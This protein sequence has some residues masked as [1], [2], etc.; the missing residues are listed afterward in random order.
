MKLVEIYPLTVVALR[1]FRNKGGKTHSGQE[2]VTIKNATDKVKL[3]TGDKK[4]NLFKEEKILEFVFTK[5]KEWKEG[6]LA[7]ESNKK[8]SSPYQNFSKQQKEWSK[9]YA[10]GLSKTIKSSFDLQK[11]KDKLTRDTNVSSKDI[12]KYLKN[13]NAIK[14]SLISEGWH[15]GIENYSFVADMSELEGHLKTSRGP[16]KCPKCSN[17]L[18]FK[19]FSKEEDKEENE[20][21]SWKCVCPSCKSKLTVF[22]T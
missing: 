12:A 6:K 22:N 1:A 4:K 5:S 17:V 10:S 8:T 7:G 18:N 20:I 14:E 3:K 21:L 16:V 2:T 19:D 15:K 11:L 13:N 9:G